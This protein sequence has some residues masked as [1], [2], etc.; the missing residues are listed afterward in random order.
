MVFALALECRAGHHGV[1]ERRDVRVSSVRRDDGQQ[2]HQRDAGLGETRES[3]D[4]CTH[5]L[6]ASDLLRGRARKH[7]IIEG[8]GLRNTPRGWAIASSRGS[9]T[10]SAIT[11]TPAIFAAGRGSWRQSIRRRPRDKTEFFGRRKVA[12]ACRE[13][14]EAGRRDADPSGG[15]TSPGARRRPLFRAAAGDHSGRGRSHRRGDGGL[16]SR[17][18]RSLIS[19]ATATALAFFGRQVR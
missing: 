17:R 4:A 9:K 12:G 18:V 13:M 1:R 11:R 3:L 7:Q 19:T 2:V 16:C 5:L 8:E 6:R 15:R 10:R 14:V